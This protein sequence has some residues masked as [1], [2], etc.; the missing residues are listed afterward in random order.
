[1]NRG[2]VNVTKDQV[3]LYKDESGSANLLIDYS[4]NLEQILKKENLI[5]AID[6]NLSS[7]EEEKNSLWND[8][9]IRINNITIYNDAIASAYPMYLIALSNQDI[10]YAIPAG[11]TGAIAAIGSVLE[12]LNIKDNKNCDL[13]IISRTRY[14][15]LHKEKE[16]EALKQL[17]E[18][19]VKCSIDKTASSYKELSQW[20]INVF[21]DRYDVFT[22]MSLDL[23]GLKQFLKEKQDNPDDIIYYK[24]YSW[25][26][27][28]TEIL[29][30]SLITKT[31][32]RTK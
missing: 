14:L 16:L 25:T 26:N 32:I 13:S 20:D 22:Q 5:E 23:I 17:R 8:M 10:K 1:M 9:P 2:Y 4:T 19:T 31:K 24:G 11:I 18:T 21:N 12:N 15:N 27:E 30:D 3:L 28:E 29:S 6:N 7:L